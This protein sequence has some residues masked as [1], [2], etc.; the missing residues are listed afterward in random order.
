MVFL[1]NS[2]RL[3]RQ[4]KNSFPYFE[5]CLLPNKNYY[6]SR[7]SFDINGYVMSPSP[8]ASND[9]VVKMVDSLFGLFHTKFRKEC[10]ENIK[11]YR[12]QRFLN[13]NE[14]CVTIFNEMLKRK[15]VEVPKSLGN[16]YRLKIG[17][18]KPRLMKKFVINKRQIFKEHLDV[19]RL[20]TTVLFGKRFNVSKILG[21]YDYEIRQVFIDYFGS[22]IYYSNY[23]TIWKMMYRSFNVVS[24]CVFNPYE[25]FQ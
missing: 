21:I 13:D 2:V 8:H 19:K 4:D 12:F 23:N 5:S 15:N 6:Y 11:N 24:G 16:R 7:N 18:D 3:R 25:K 14:Y 17:P 22:S 10:D 20:K 1:N 9:E